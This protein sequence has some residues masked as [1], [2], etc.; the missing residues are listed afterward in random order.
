MASKL[1][2]IK[3]YRNM[4]KQARIWEK[5]MSSPKV[6]TNIKSA[7]EIRRHTNS[8]LLVKKQ[9]E[10]GISFIKIIIKN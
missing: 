2:V 7:F 3:L 5:S 4:L 9:I 8:D 6:S 1:E 10:D